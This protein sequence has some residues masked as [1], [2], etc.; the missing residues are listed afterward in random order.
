MTINRKLLV[1][2][3]ALALTLV[4]VFQSF[5]LASATPPEP[6]LKSSPTNGATGDLHQSYSRLE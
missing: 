3:T 6:L 1:S 5:G 4:L 2:V